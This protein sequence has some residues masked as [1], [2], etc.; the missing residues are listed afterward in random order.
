MGKLKKKISKSK[1]FNVKVKAILV[2]GRAGL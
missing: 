1:H 2:T